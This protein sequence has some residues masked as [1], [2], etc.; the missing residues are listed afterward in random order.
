[1]RDLFDDFWTSSAAARPTARGRGSR[2]RRPPTATLEP[3][4]ARA[5]RDG[6]TTTTA[7]TITTRTRRRDDADAR[8]AP[9]PR[10]LRDRSPAGRTTAGARAGPPAVVVGIAA[11]G[12][13]HPGLSSLFSFGLD[14]WTDAL[15]FHSVGFDGVF[16]TRIGAQAGLF[17]LRARAGPGRPAGQPVARRPPDAA[18]DP[19]AGGTVRNLF[20]AAQRGGRGRGGPAHRR[21]AALEP[22]GRPPI[23]ADR[24]ERRRHPG[25]EPD[26]DVGP[27]RI[28]SSSSPSAS[29]GRWPRPGRPCCSGSTACRSRQTGLGHRPDLRPR[30]RVLPVRAAV[31]ASRPGALQRHRH[32]GAAPRG[33]ALPGRCDRAGRWSS[34]RRSA[35]TSRSSA[36]CSSCRSRSAT[37]ST[38]SSWSTARESVETSAIDTIGV[39]F[40]DQHAQFFAYDVLTVISGLAAAFLVG[41][42]F[43]RMLWPFGLTLGVWFLASI[44]IGRAY[45]G[46]RPVLHGAAQP[47]RAGGAVHLEQHRDDAARIRTRRMGGQPAV[48]GRG[49]AHRGGDRQRRGHVPQRPPVGLP[50]AR[51]LLRPA[52]GHPAVLRLHRRRHRPLHD[53]RRPAPGD[54]LGARARSRAPSAAAGSTSASTSRTGSAWRWHRSTR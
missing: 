29:A 43:T 48:R 22:S 37:S 38:S 8:S 3:S 5:R 15:W 53:R 50:A 10:P 36:A 12:R 20:D 47:V 46:G 18:A 23:G 31:P 13:P 35:C 27:G 30:H 34:P 42:A 45:P 39:S 51:R 2:R 11:F 19:P 41:A 52:P 1:M 14:L 21:S 40:T 54:A 32:H 49:E 33:R 25:P 7:R 6:T 9:P 16:W 44:L 4:R 17:A 28:W 26:R 24:L